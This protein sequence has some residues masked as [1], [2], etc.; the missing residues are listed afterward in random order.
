MPSALVIDGDRTFCDSLC[1]MLG[2]LDVSARPAYNA[3]A[4]LLTLVDALPDLIFLSCQG[5]KEGCE[6]LEFLEFLQGESALAEIPV[7]MVVEEDN[8]DTPQKMAQTGVMAFM[9]RPA[10]LQA[11]ERVLRKAGLV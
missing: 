6:S 10:S 11:L 9:A 3:R 7:V 2:L 5:D 8:E 4:A 1:Q